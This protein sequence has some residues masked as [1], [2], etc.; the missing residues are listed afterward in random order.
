MPEV[1]F[2]L[3]SSKKFEDQEKVGHNRWHPEIPP[4]VSINEAVEM[5]KQF[6]GMESGRFVNGILDRAVKDLDRP[7]RCA[8]PDKR[9]LPGEP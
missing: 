8:Q 4:V 1:I 7:T 9:L 6:G 5:A 2:P 3:D